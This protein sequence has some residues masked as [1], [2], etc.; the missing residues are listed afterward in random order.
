MSESI[1]IIIKLLSTLVSPKACL[2]Y[3]LIALF[4]PLGWKLLW[5][6]SL[7]D[8]VSEEHKKII[9]LLVSIGL[10]SIIVDL[11]GFAINKFK[12]KISSKRRDNELRDKRSIDDENFK[13]IFRQTYNHLSDEQ[14]ILLERLLFDNCTV[15]LSSGGDK[16][17]LD[18]KFILEIQNVSFYEVVVE[19]NP[20]IRD[21]VIEKQ[22]QMTHWLVEDY[23]NETDK[24]DAQKIL[25]L[26][27][28]RPNIETIKVKRSYLDSISKSPI[29]I[30]A[31]YSI[32]NDGYHI[33]F[34][35]D[36]YKEYF[37]SNY[38]KK[39]KDEIFI[40]SRCLI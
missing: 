23:F 39:Y 19:I 4:L 25:R 5:Q 11:V 13:Q 29:C 18:N 3:I 12:Q 40:D 34:V 28:E 38:G 32:E 36:R 21:I 31:S 6:S 37:E 10:G 7:I 27:E 2:K 22:N 1:N 14:V 15:K 16:T 20:L 33:W 8:N 9:I 24:E 30:E 17:L 35:R 26:F